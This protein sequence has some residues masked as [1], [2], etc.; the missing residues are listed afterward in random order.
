MIEELEKITKT[1]LTHLNYDSEE[2][3]LVFAKL[4]KDNNVKCEAP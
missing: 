4:A 3:R 1:K 2:A